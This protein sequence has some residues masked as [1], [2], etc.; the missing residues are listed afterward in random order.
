MEYDLIIIG[1]GPGGYVPAIR[2]GQT[3]LRTA[4]IE[5]D[6][7]G[8][9]CLNRGCI[10]TKAL[11]ESA[12]LFRKIQNAG[13]F[14]VDGI[15]P[16]S[17]SFNYL[18]AVKRTKRIVARLTKG[19]EFL[20]KK[21]GVELIKGEASIK[22]DSTIVVNDRLLK[23]KNIIIATGSVVDPL[24]EIFKSTNSV[25]IKEML[26]LKELP[27]E[28][29]IYGSGIHAIEL[30]QFVKMTGR[31]V[32]IITFDPASLEDLD[33]FLV[34]QIYRKLKKEKINVFELKD[35][36][37]K[38]N[39]VFIPGNDNPADLIINAGKRKAVVPTCE[40]ALKESNGFIE[41]NEKFMCSGENIFAVGDVNGRSYFAQAASAQ[42]LFAVNYIRGVRSEYDP[43]KIPFNIYTY[44]EMAQIGLTMKELTDRKVDYKVSEFSLMANGKALSEGESEGLVRILSE[45]KY[46]EVLG[47]QIISQ[48]ATDMIAEAA[49]LMSIEGT[50]F[51]VANIIHAHPTISEVFYEAGLDA[52]DLA[53]HK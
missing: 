48:N 5:K 15:E 30:A 1:S 6:K 21:H 2:A 8:G 4:I 14:G 16:G 31:N 29:I 50:V 24:P 25:N 39:E 46:G 18:K 41:T 51:D 38:N 52:L 43:A 19:V 47:V 20:L 34:E 23:T 22:D 11:I 44:P 9:M 36:T 10:P 13:D 27:E 28:I 26:E 53:I 3:G 32:S 45:K 17:L 37:I 40:L 12:K 33:D 35:I 7:T 42:G 49:A